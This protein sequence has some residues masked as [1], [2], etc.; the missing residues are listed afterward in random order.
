[1]S[2]LKFYY[3]KIIAFFMIFLI[4][5]ITPVF[6]TN[7]NI[8]GDNVI[9]VNNEKVVGADSDFRVEISNVS[10]DVYF[11]NSGSCSACDN[12]SACDNSGDTKICY[13]KAP[14]SAGKKELFFVA[15][16]SGSFSNLGSTSYIL[17]NSSPKIN[18]SNEIVDGHNLKF[19]YTI[20]DELGASVSEVYCSGI[21]ELRVFVNNNLEYSNIVNSANCEINSGVNFEITPSSILDIDIAVIDRVGN[22]NYPV[23]INNLTMDADPPLVLGSFEILQN[24]EVLEKIAVNPSQVPIVDIKL[25]IYEEELVSVMGNIKDFNNL[26]SQNYGY[27][28]TPANCFLYANNSYECRFKNI[29]LHPGSGKLSINLTAIDSQNNI[30]K[31]LIEREYEV[32]NAAN[33]V[34][35]IGPDIDK[36]CD[37]NNKCFVND[38]TI[39]DVIINGG[40]DALFNT[41]HV[42][43]K[44]SQISEQTLENP[45]ECINNMDTWVCSYFVRINNELPSGTTKWIYIDNLASD[46]FGRALD[47]LSKQQVT[48]DFD[49]P[50]INKF[51]TYVNNQEVLDFCLKPSDKLNIELEAS[52][53]VSTELKIWAKT[54]VTL[55]DIHEAK[56]EKIDTGFSCKLDIT[57]FISMQ[58]ENKEIT[59]NVEDLAGNII[60]KNITINLCI[61]NLE[62]VPT[63]VT[64]IKEKNAYEEFVDKR[65]ATFKYWKHYIPL[66][67]TLVNNP[68]VHL[69][70]YEIT[71]CEAYDSDAG[72]DYV[73][74]SSD[75]YY[76]INKGP[77][78]ATAVVLIGS[79]SIPAELT[80]QKLT[81]E[82]DF[83]G[84]I[85]G[86]Y[87]RKTQDLN[88]TVD[89]EFENLPIS[90]PDKNIEDEI[91]RMKEDL[92]NL[93]EYIEKREGINNIMKI[94]CTTG[95]TAAA[96]NSILQNIDVV[97]FSLSLIPAIGQVIFLPIFTIFHPIAQSS[98]AKT[99][100]W[101]WPP[102]NVYSNA[103]NPTSHIRPGFYLKTA[104]F[105]YNCHY[106]DTQEAIQFFANGLNDW[107]KKDIT[108]MTGIFNDGKYTLISTDKE[109]YYIDWDT[110]KLEVFSPSSGGNTFYTSGKF[111]NRLIQ[112]ASDT[113]KV[114]DALDFDSWMI[115]PYK[116]EHYDN[117]CID[118]QIF[119]ANKRKQISC[120]YI[121]CL[122]D[123][124]GTGLGKEVCTNLYNYRDC[125]YLESAEVKLHGPGGA[126]WARLPQVLMSA[127]LGTA[128]SI[129][130][131]IVC[132]EYFFDFIP[133]DPVRQ[134]GCTAAVIPITYKEIQ[135]FVTGEIFKDFA[136]NTNL[137]DVCSGISY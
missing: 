38:N 111:K 136:S 70:N 115:N 98:L 105:I 137:G 134:I 58:Q 2:M 37:E 46:D 50:T 100:Y 27:E 130:F 65:V 35:H 69:I 31:T 67:F 51:K 135:G 64:K 10:N 107:L 43:I 57:H 5:S 49:S 54:N 78:Y 4:V 26:P 106:Y 117:L 42:P 74:G 102:G 90:G 94:L 11:N 95:K 92:R 13:F 80:S 82:I 133:L 45:F 86:V 52:D 59:I 39:I 88:F 60:T 41:M 30:L 48:L 53:D 16:V 6:A 61:A 33:E 25:N 97:L 79:N 44:V 99:T 85:G 15:N 81:C 104:C 9:N 23:S 75:S 124:K 112:G 19:N 83:L 36:Q 66:E 47:G 127:L 7:F 62:D 24:E 120:M 14:S 17:D 84:R 126:F 32:V 87:F 113:S 34:I 72:L 68:N 3:K 118:A 131:Q 119:N 12:Y 20:K 29:R 101:L 76:F 123:I 28:V 55:D 1:M 63:L 103:I 116:S 77:E 132:P 125:L 21:K 121:N 91:D 40:E 114:T 93:D 128:A 110:S 8:L 18:F 109:L 22:R 96:L 56:C 108:E 122:E 89:L 129:V 73:Y 71:N